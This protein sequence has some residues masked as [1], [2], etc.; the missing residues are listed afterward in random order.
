MPPR[1]V[2]ESVCPPLHSDCVDDFEEALPNVSG[3]SP[4]SPAPRRRR[5]PPWASEDRH[6]V[7]ET[8][9]S[10][11][12][13]SRRSCDTAVS[14]APPSSPMAGGSDGI[15]GRPWCPP[16]AA[17][18]PRPRLRHLG[19]S[20]VST[21]ETISDGGLLDRHSTGA[22]HSR[23]G[24]TAWPQ[25]PI[26][27]EDGDSAPHSQTGSQLAA[28]W[29]DVACGTN[30]T[31]VDSADRRQDAADA[32][33]GSGLPARPN[34]RDSAAEERILNLPGIN[35]SGAAERGVAEPSSDGL[36]DVYA[37]TALGLASASQLPPLQRSMAGL[38]PVAAG[39]LISA[40]D[41]SSAQL[42]VALRLAVPAQAA[43]LVA[44]DM[45]RPVDRRTTVRK[46]KVAGPPPLGLGPGSGLLAARP[47]NDNCALI[48][49][50]A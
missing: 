7:D 24:V 46:L 34:S 45:P 12:G 5:P 3:G 4:R 15:P 19:A 10:P 9:V 36:R 40:R 13:S 49:V 16:T 21:Q 37:V 29:G 47:V 18:P 35:T 44:P 31:V 25:W 39:T 2:P 17:R 20:A 1:D 32:A 38:S 43:A 11:A 14:D 8:S 6:G 28:A 30:E 42:A 50:R 48:E 41:I 26:P 22:E 27:R 23:P 33:A